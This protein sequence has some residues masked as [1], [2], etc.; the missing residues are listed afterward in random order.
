MGERFVVVPVDILGTGAREAER[1]DSIVPDPA[2][3]TGGSGSSSNGYAGTAQE[4]LEDSV[5][6]PQDPDVVVPILKYSREPNKYGRTA[7]VRGPLLI[8][9]L[10]CLS[11]FLR[12]KP[13][14]L[15]RA[16]FVQ[17]WLLEHP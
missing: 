10:T 14:C 5:F 1:L 13:P 12:I 7:A 6:E 17:Q 8:L 15:S 2:P 4:P 3:D 16:L 9:S 11:V